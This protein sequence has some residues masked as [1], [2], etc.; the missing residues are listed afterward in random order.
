MAETGNAAAMRE[1]I[2]TMRRYAMLPQE[3][4]SLSLLQRTIHEKCDAALAA[5]A[6]NCDVYRTEDE[7][8]KA[9]DG[10]D[11]N[12]AGDWFAFTDWLFAPAKKGET[13]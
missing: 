11:E 5:P 4:L 9:W 8:L 2:K 1:S 10:L 3:Q 7:A 13:K 6:R 12:D